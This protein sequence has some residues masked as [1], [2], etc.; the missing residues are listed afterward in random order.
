MLM[1][2]AR[3]FVLNAQLVPLQRTMDQSPSQTVHPALWVPIN[4]SLAPHPVSSV[5]L[6]NPILLIDRVLVLIAT[7]DDSLIPLVW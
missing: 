5:L 4:L 7:L 3:P 6:D 2:L 1:H